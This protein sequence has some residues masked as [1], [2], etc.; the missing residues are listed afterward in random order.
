[1]RACRHAVA[2]AMLRQGV[3]ATIKPYSPPGCALTY[4][5]VLMRSIPGLYIFF[6]FSSMEESVLTG[7]CGLSHM[8]LYL[9]IENIQL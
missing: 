8:P 7:E 2:Q 4:Q 9:I 1:M 5:V 3:V 6:Q